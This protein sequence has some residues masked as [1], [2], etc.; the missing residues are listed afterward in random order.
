[1]APVAPGAAVARS[2]SGAHPLGAMRALILFV[3]AASLARPA[4]AQA[5]P[6]VAIADADPME[7]ARVVDRLGDDAV[8]ERLDAAR[9]R[10]VRLAATRAAPFM[11]WPEL[12]LAQLARIAAGRDPLLAPAA[13]QAAVV[14]AR[15]LD[16]D[17]LRRREVDPASLAAARAAFEALSRD[18][19]ARADIQAVAGM[20][21]SMLERLGAR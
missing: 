9:P 17:Q 6:L 14:I 21:A 7:L 19:D 10:E 20:V 1:M 15:G 8:I 5:D 13:A 4:S 2:P 11:S 18:E 16:V 3:L 12:A